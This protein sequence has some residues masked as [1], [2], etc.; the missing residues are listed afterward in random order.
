MDILYMLIF[1]SIGL[2]GAI[3]W[4]FLWAIHSGQFDDLEGPAHEILMDND[5][6]KAKNSTTTK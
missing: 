2:I 6:V 1:L 5:D 4:F 3:V